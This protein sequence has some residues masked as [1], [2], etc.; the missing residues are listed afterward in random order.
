MNSIYSERWIFG[1]K[2]DEQFRDFGGRF[3]LSGGHDDVFAGLIE[4]YR[5][6]CEFLIE[7]FL[8]STTTD[9]LKRKMGLPHFDVVNNSA[10]KSMICR[11]DQRYCL[12]FNSGTI[13]NLLNL[14][15]ILYSNPKFRPEVGVADEEI[16]SN[17]KVF[18]DCDWMN[19]ISLIFESV[20][21]DGIRNY[22]FP[23]DS[24]R[25]IAAEN[26]T[27][28]ALRFLVIRS[29]S[30]IFLGHFEYVRNKYDLEVFLDLSTH[31]EI[32]AIDRFTLELKAD[33]QAANIMLQGIGG[34]NQN[35]SD[36]ADY[37][38]SKAYLEHWILA[39]G[40]VFLIESGQNDEKRM[41]NP[42]E[43]WADLRMLSMF[44]RNLNGGDLRDED[45][46]GI[47]EALLKSSK[48]IIQAQEEFGI[49]SK[50]PFD[51]MDHSNA[52]LTKRLI[53]NLKELEPEME[54]YRMV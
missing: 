19:S 29:L 41:I 49:A 52:S 14:F 7:H 33:Y 51:I 47:E 4:W 9:L 16:G 32:S 30:H 5:E 20:Q 37:P 1:Q 15:F 26:C 12:G 6:H 28:L 40:M 24:E 48:D 46:D 31:P 22:S 39:V 35:A 53:R 21:P 38:S 8:S 25:Y 17:F 36:Q 10:V 27:K 43:P 42:N 13:V 34:F 23:R 11:I 2:F 45:T 50:I 3:T 44:S 18:Q 54:K